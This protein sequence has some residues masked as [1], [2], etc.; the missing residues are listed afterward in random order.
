MSVVDASVWVAAMVEKDR[1]HRESR[2]WLAHRINAGESL[3]IPELAL[4]EIAGAIARR[5]G[6]ATLGVR[7][8]RRVLATPRLT[9]VAANGPTWRLATMLAAGLGLRGADAVYLAVARRLGEPLVTWDGEML[10]RAGDDV[11]VVSPERTT[12]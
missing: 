10:A 8:V 6:E 11:T 1:H 7:A 5:T 12:M 4:P 9:L 3:A 2:A